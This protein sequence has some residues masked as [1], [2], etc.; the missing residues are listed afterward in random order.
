MAAEQALPFTSDPLTWISAVTSA[1]GNTTDHPESTSGNFDQFNGLQPGLGERLNL[2]RNYVR[3]M[4]MRMQRGF[5]LNALVTLVMMADVLVFAS[6][7][8]FADLEAEKNMSSG[9]ILRYIIHARFESNWIVFM[10]Y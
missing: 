9:G 3:E 2:V 1:P 7:L 4:R 8:N 10:L 5:G 6:S